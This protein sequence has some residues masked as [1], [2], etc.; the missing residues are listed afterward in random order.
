MHIVAQPFHQH[1]NPLN[2]VISRLVLQARVQS[3]LKNLV[4]GF[5]EHVASFDDFREDLSV[6]AE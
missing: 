3:R 1:H 5:R 6:E 4:V 2:G